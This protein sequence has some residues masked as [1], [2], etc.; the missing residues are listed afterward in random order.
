TPD[1]TQPDA[2]G[3]RVFLVDMQGFALMSKEKEAALIKLLV[4]KKVT[5]IPTLSVRRRAVVEDGGRAV[6]ED[7]GYARRAALAYVPGPVRKEWSEAS[8]DKNIREAF[9]EEEMNLMR[10]GYRRLELFVR[11]FRRR[12]GTVVAGSD[13]LSGVAG[14]TLHRAMESLVAVGLKPMEALLAATRDAARFL[15]RD[16]IGTIEPG[17]KADLLIVGASPLADI[18]NVGAVEKVFQGGREINIEFQ[19]DYPLP[20]ARPKLTRPLLL[21]RLLEKER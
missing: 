14:L 16:E 21:E 8:L 1:E 7:G 5:L 20:P 15:R 13:N 11:E 2:R 6:A 12:G 9:N 3:L 17:K 19:P 10:A 4:E 18:R